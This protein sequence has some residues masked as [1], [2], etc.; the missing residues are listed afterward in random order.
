MLATFRSL[1]KARGF[2]SLAVGMIGVAICGVT[3]VMSLI[4]GALLDPGTNRDP[5]RIVG[6]EINSPLSPGFLH[7]G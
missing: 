6:I 4:S 3:L 7:A 5:E 1:W 2:T